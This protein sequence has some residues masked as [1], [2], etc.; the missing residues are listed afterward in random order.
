MLEFTTSTLRVRTFTQVQP[1]LSGLARLVG[2]DA[3]TVTQLNLRSRHEIAVLWPPR[4]PVLDVLPA[5]AALGHTHP[6]RAPLLRLAESPPARALPV[7]IS[8]VLTPRAWK[9]TPLYLEAMTGTSDQLCLPM[10]FSGATVR[11]VTLSRFSGAFTVRQRDVLAAC[12]E[13]LSFAFCRSRP[14]GQFG[15]QL[16]PHPARIPL[17]VAGPPVRTD[18]TEPGELDETLLSPRERQVLHLMAAALTDAQIARRLGLRPATVSKHL[19]RVYTRLG[20]RNRVDAARM[21]TGRPAE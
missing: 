10:S 5:Y 21:W 9:A 11:A 18:E 1:L 16:A 4:R 7:R 20:L 14:N 13:H 8:D 12:A 17:A 3:A 6:L 19:H 2:S 15:L